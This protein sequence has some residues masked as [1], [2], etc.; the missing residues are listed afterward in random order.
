MKKISFIEILSQM[1]NQEVERPNKS[2]NGT[3]Q[4]MLLVSRLK[5]LYIIY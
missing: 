5:S 4:V 1:V 3:F 2:S